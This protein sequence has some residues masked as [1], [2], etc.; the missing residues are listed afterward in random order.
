MTLKEIEERKKELSEKISNGALKSLLERF[1]ATKDKRQKKKTYYDHIK[2]LFDLLGLP[3]YHQQT[4]M[5]MIIAP[6][7]GMRKS[8]FATLIELTNK[9]VVEDLIEIGLIYEF[10]WNKNIQCITVV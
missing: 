5:K 6:D 2:D 7:K 10:E 9:N 1:S 8:F 3:E 4:L